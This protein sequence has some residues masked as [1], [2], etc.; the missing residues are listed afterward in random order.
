[1]REKHT[2]TVFLQRYVRTQ[3]STFF[4]HGLC[5]IQEFDDYGNHRVSVNGVL[6]DWYAYKTIIKMK[7]GEGFVGST[8]DYYEG[9]LPRVFVFLTPPGGINARG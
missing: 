1:M 8:T 4:I 5:I 9:D 6:S 7:V 3:H 2:G